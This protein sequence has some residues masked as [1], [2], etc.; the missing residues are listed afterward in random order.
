M[1]KLLTTAAMLVAL[2]T[3]TFADDVGAETML[4]YYHNTCADLLYPPEISRFKRTVSNASPSTIRAGQR[5]IENGLV[6]WGGEERY[7]GMLTELI[8]QDLPELGKRIN[9]ATTSTWDPAVNG[10]RDLCPQRSN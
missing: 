8:K 9:A 1:Y 3:P 4:L 5:I 2:C 10:R 7:C 6:F